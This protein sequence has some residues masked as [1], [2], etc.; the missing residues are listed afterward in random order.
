MKT[1]L[2]FALLPLLA[3][4]VSP[5]SLVLTGQNQGASSFHSKLLAVDSLMMIDGSGNPTA[6]WLAYETEDINAGTYTR[7]TANFLAGVTGISSMSVSEYVPDAVEGGPA[8]IRAAATLVTPEVI[9]I[10]NHT[11]TGHYSNPNNRFRFV[12]EDGT[13]RVWEGNI[14]SSTAWVQLSDD[15]GVIV[16]A[17]QA[18][19]WI[20]TAKM[21]APQFWALLLPD[22]WN[23]PIPK[24]TPCAPT[25]FPAL[26]WRD[27]Y[28]YYRVTE[29]QQQLASATEITIITPTTPPSATGYWI[30]DQNAPRPYVPGSG[31]ASGAVYT[32]N[33]RHAAYMQQQA[34]SGDSGSGLFFVINNELYAL[35]SWHFPTSGPDWTKR[36]ADINAAIIAG[37]GTTQITPVDPTTL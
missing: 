7:N 25:R 37:G 26:V 1:F 28:L 35:A 5:Q 16:L 24:T 11:N 20:K 14:K 30:R 17:S 8:G 13:N 18:P 21:L 29:I 2:L 12:A 9:L 22:R 6:G 10:A 15:I 23:I 33:A 36:I 31:Q 19:S 34:Y 3:L 32:A 27:Q 4:A